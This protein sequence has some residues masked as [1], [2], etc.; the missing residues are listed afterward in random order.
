MS[1]GRPYKCVGT[2]A[3]VRG[4]IARSNASGSRLN[5]TGSTSAK[6][7]LSPATRAISGMTQKVSAGQNDLRVRRNPQRLEQIVEGHPAVRRAHRM[8]SAHLHCERVLERCDVRA[9]NELALLPQCVDGLL[10]VRNHT[11]A[12]PRNGS[13]H[14][15]PRAMAARS[16]R[17]CQ[18]SARSS[19]RPTSL[20]PRSGSPQ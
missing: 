14:V 19:N 6:T 1:Q 8:R 20:R 3:R 16:D 9:V 11:R 4:V 7:G 5:V 17:S 10:R 2:T 15:T 12:V 13:Q 18:L